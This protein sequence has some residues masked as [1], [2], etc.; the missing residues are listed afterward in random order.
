M[1]SHLRIAVVDDNERMRQLAETLAL[2]LITQASAEYPFFFRATDNGLA[3]FHQ[4]FKHPLH[5]ALNNRRLDS[6]GKRS[7]L[8]KAC[9]LNKHRNLHILDATTGLARDSLALLFLGARVT[10]LERS[11]FLFALLQ[12]AHARLSRTQPAL[13]ANWQLH[14]ADAINYLQQTMTFDGILLDPMFPARQ[15]SALVKKEMRIIHE[16]VGNDP[17]ADSLFTQACQQITRRVVVKRPLHAATLQHQAPTHQ[18]TGKTIRYDV[19]LQSV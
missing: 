15:K 12:D 3:L 5:I 2:P 7:L 19:Y 4:Q 1:T 13:A 14:Q 6:M 8:A 16:L 18:L 17:D 11:P 9:G 10:S